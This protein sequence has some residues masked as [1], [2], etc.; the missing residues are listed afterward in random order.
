M[1]SKTTQMSV[2]VSEEDAE[3]LADFEIAGANT[4]SE[5]LR[6]LIAQARDRQHQAHSYEGALG[7]VRELL[8]PVA[9]TLRARELATRQRSEMIAD[10]L[11][12]LPD[13]VAYLIAG[14]GAKPGKADAKE[15]V[16]FEAGVAHRIFRFTDAMLRLAVT[17]T[18]PCYDPNVVAKHMSGTLELAKLVL[19][20]SRKTSS[21]A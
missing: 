2:R 11:Y 10:T 9:Q 12:W 7:L 1:S 4:P 16:E 15:L 5:K 17:S 21:G 13:V 19:E 8:E 6:H 18:A 14:P 3:F 20:Q